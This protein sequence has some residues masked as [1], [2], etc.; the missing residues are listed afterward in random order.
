MDVTKTTWR[1][2]GWRGH[3]LRGVALAAA[4]LAACGGELTGPDATPEDPDGGE[5]CVDADGD[6][7]G[8]GCSAGPDCDDDDPFHFSDCAQ[9]L[10]GPAAGC[11]CD[12]AAPVS[13][14]D[15]PDGTAGVGACRAGQRSCVSG[16]WS[17]CEGQVEPMLG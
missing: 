9:C 13:C 10:A 17:D 4:M 12:G 6:G 3:A 5:G 2:I 16:A 15:G 11:A 14:Y 7:H 1:P 8:A